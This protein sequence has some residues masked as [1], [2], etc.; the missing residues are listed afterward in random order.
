[1]VT[2]YAILKNG[3]SPF[4]INTHISTANHPRILNLVPTESLEIA[5]LPDCQICKLSNIN[6]YEYILMKTLK[7]GKHRRNETPTKLPISQLLRF[8]EYQTWYHISTM[9]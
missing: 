6:I 3:C 5:L 8:L 4:Y 2:H 7:F 1:M 9:T